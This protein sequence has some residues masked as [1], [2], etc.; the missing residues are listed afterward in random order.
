MNVFIKYSFSF[1]FNTAKIEYYLT[2]Y[3]ENN[4][5]LFPSDLSLYNDFHVFCNIKINNN[6]SVY[7]LTNIYDKYYSCI[8]FFNLNEIINF[9]LEVYY[10][11]ENINYSNFF[12]F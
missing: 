8:E 7:S 3:D 1:K 9:G 10:N 12:L 4:N 11:Y 2:F 5:I 6:H